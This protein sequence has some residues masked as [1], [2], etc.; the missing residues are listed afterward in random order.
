RERAGGDRSRR[1]L[2]GLRAAL[3]RGARHAGRGRRAREGRRRAA[4][5]R[6]HDGR[7]VA[8]LRE[9]APARRGRAM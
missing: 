5:P 2:G 7:G 4:P 3:R 8:A 1:A 9:R 6:R